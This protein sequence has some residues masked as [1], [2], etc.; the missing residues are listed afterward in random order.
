MSARTSVLNRDRSDGWVSGSAVSE[1]ADGE[2]AYHDIQVPEGASRLDVVMTWDEPPADTLSSTVL[3]DLDLWLDHGADCEAEPC[4]EYASQ[5]RVD[6]V[7]WLIVSDPKP[8]T[9]RVKIA[10]SRVYTDPPRAAVAW[11]TILGAST[12][13]LDISLDVEQVEYAQDQQ[14]E[15]VELKVTLTADEYV[16]AGTQLQ[17]ECRRIDGTGCPH[18]RRFVGEGEFRIT[19]VREDGI[20]QSETPYIHGAIEVG[21][22]AVGEIWEGKID[23]RFRLAGSDAEA[24]RLYVKASAWNANP[25]SASILVRKQGVEDDLPEVATPSF[26]RFDDATPLSGAEG[27]FEVDLVAAQPEPGEPSFSS[28]RRGRGRPAGSVWLTWTAPSDDMVTFSVTPDAAYGNMDLVRMDAFHGDS[29]VSLAQVA[30]SHWA[31]QFFASSGR[32]YVIR[33]SDAGATSPLVLN[34]TSG[35]RPVNDDF[36][37]ATV[38]SDMGGITE[39]S[40]A[41]ATLESGEFFSG[42]A[43]TVWYHWIAPSDGAW[44]FESSIGELRVVAFLGASLANLRLVSGFPSERAVFPARAGEAYRIAVASDHAGAAG[45]AFELTWKSIEREAGNDNF[46]G[47]LEIPSEEMSSYP[48]HIDRDATVEPGEPTESGIRTKWWSWLA[49]SDGHYVW[50]LEDLTGDLQEFG[51]KLMV[52]FFEGAS[53]D[54]LELVATNGSNMSVEFSFYAHGGRQ[55]WVSVGIPTHDDW[56]FR[57]IYWAEPDSTL[58]WGMTPENDGV[59]SS[60]ALTGVSGTVSGSNAFATTA[61]GERSDVLG[62]ATLWWTYEALESGWVRF[63]VDGDGGPWALAVFGGTVDDRS[64]LSFLVSDRWQRLENEVLFEAQAGV[65]YTISLG[66]RDGG[67]GGEFTL[68]WEESED[69]GWLRFVAG[70]ADGNLDSRGNRVTIRRPGDFTIDDSGGSLYLASGLGL[71]AFERN[72]M[73]GQLEHVQLLETEF[74]L[75]L[76]ALIWDS[77]RNRLLVTSCGRWWSFARTDDDITLGNA[78]ELEATDD[79]RACAAH[80]ELLLMDS[81]SSDIYRSRRSFIDHFTVESDGALRFVESKQPTEGVL[82]AVLSNDQRHVYVASSTELQVY[83]RDITSGELS[84]SDFTYPLS[85]P[86]VPPA[87]LAITDDDAHLLVFDN[88]GERANLF[89]LEDPL[90]PNLKAINSFYR[91]PSQL[92]RCRFADARTDVVAVDVLCP[93]MVFSVRWDAEVEDLVITD[94][95]IEGEADRFNNLTPSFGEPHYEAPSGFAVSPDDRYIYLSTPAHGILIFGRGSPLVD[96]DGPDLVVSSISVEN[97]ETEPGSNFELHATVRNEGNEE[98]DPTTL[99]V[100]RSDDASISSEDT[101][102]E[103]ISVPS[104]DASGVHG[105]SIQLT[106]PSDVGAYYYGACVSSVEGETDEANNC[107]TAVLV[108]VT[109]VEITGMPDLV[110]ES[111]SVDND[112]PETGGSF[113]FSAMVRNKGNA[114][115]ERT[116]LRF[117]QST[118]PT[119]SSDDTQIGTDEVA[120]LSVGAV[121]NVS[122]GLTAPS[123]VGTFYFGA[124]V[125]AVSDESNDR[126]NCSTGVRVEV[127]D[128]ETGSDSFCRDDDVIEPGNRCDIYGTD[129]YFEVLSNGCHVF[130]PFGTGSFCGSNANYRSGSIRL[131]ASRNANDSWTITNVE[132]EPGDNNG[133]DSDDHG[134]TLNTATRVN[135]PSTTSGEL[136]SDGDLDYFRVDLTEATTLVAETQGSIDTYGTLLDRT[137]DTLEV[138]DDGGSDTNFKLVWNVGAGTY[139]IEVKGYSPSTQGRYELILSEDRSVS[140]DSFGAISYDFNVSDDCPG[141]AAGMTLDKASKSEASSTARAACQAD[142]GNAGECREGTDT[143]EGCAAMAYGEL[144]GTSCDVYVHSDDSSSPSLSGVESSALAACRSDGNT[145]C[146]IFSNGS[147]VR[148]S[149]CNSQ[150]ERA[151]PRVAS[152][153]RSSMVDSRTKQIQL[154]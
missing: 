47:A 128:D 108:T 120:R 45:T 27:T 17:F 138:N 59:Y 60:A 40:N 68:S 118:N 34:W 1:I 121:V 77:S 42:L 88:D 26:D 49:P 131:V 123:N 62:R 66:S 19:S 64:N 92:N 12:P 135:I 114:A 150:A 70:I 137:G 71:H 97:A 15:G 99:H 41:G 13:N 56:A 105:V 73:T 2:Y 20:V 83:T 33:I 76:A 48:V 30:S 32:E 61:R 7:E 3:N 53:L 50:R 101:V 74:D 31:I 122:R 132:P 11:T 36:K 23:V 22:L 117:Y 111:V 109:D 57:Y 124:C 81:D 91:D 130:T 82:S 44:E 39:G 119:I 107:S 75:S 29:L 5:S 133:G 113:T 149:G 54:D 134:N 145:I 63:A 25:D 112:S 37:A 106:A 142:G 16:A 148:I 65:T 154:R 43:S 58:S 85:G 136:E 116:T 147:G 104:I 94:T 98:S 9:Y 141:L 144:P 18:N 151:N 115:S 143:F 10:A 87:P 80:R 24:F 95:L 127:V 100:H 4:G 126:N 110:V 28:S 89:S 38:I 103:S 69:P 129:H 72:I 79:P 84:E 51:D 146:R 152:A 86:Y 6:N 8:G 102:V 46:E 14:S 67:R 35:M 140:G 139:Y 96:S 55:Y 153:N 90:A 93:G 125:D 78:A 52:S 21:E